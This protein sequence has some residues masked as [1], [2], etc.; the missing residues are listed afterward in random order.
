VC[1][2]PRAAAGSSPSPRRS[3]TTAKLGSAPRL[4]LSDS[5]IP[6]FSLAPLHLSS[7]AP[8]LKRPLCLLS[9]Y[10]VIRVTR[11]PIK[12]RRNLT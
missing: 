11:S 7:S 4:R 12:A 2:R 9:F 8:Q 1:S 5:P 6:R 10:K 3:V